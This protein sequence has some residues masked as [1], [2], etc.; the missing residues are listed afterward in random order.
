MLPQYVRQVWLPACA[1]LVC[2]VFVGGSEVGNC[3]TGLLMKVMKPADSS[4]INSWIDRNI[5]DNLKQKHTD[6]DAVFSNSMQA[7][8]TNVYMSYAHVLLEEGLLDVYDVDIVY[9]RR[10]MSQATNLFEIPAMKN[11]WQ[12]LDKSLMKAYSSS[13]GKKLTAFPWNK[14][15][16]ILIYRKDL[17]KK[18]GYDESEPLK[19]S[20][21]WERME[22]IASDIVEKEKKANKES[23]LEGYA[24]QGKDYE[25]LTCNLMEWIG[26]DG[27]ESQIID[28]DKVTLNQQDIEMA[29]RSLERVAR[30][31]ES[32]ITHPQ[33]L[34]N[35]ELD[36]RQ[37]FVDGNAIFV[38]YVSFKSTKHRHKLKSNNIT[39]CLNYLIQ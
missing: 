8:E 7:R 4:N 26:S 2:F 25:G 29:S 15:Q 28:G 6:I 33:V 31:I 22:E 35:I 34:E 20:F 23:T 36:V 18:Y 12:W 1:L 19:D 27:I 11:L 10:F 37:R 5:F 14:D 17:L 3:S 39:L 13:N 21:T 38:R 24:W 32:N 9:A 30:W 16:G